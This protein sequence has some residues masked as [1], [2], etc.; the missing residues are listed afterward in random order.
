MHI[1]KTTPARLSFLLGLLAAAA[2]V[3]AN[4]HAPCGSTHRDQAARAKMFELQSKLEVYRMRLGHYPDELEGL[5]A[6]I[7]N[8]NAS[9]GP[10]TR[11][12]LLEE[13]PL[14]PWN[15]PYIYRLHESPPPDRTAVE[16]ISLGSDCLL[17]T[18]DD[19]SSREQG[20]SSP[21]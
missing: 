15:S 18:D 1:L 12:P 4:Q 17:G 5:E 2:I 16:I 20:L 19:I 11:V 10:P 6:L 3:T 14:D 13:L 9:H 8:P 7:R 21:P